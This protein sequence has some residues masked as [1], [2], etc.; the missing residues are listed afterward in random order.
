MR[1]PI[2]ITTDSDGITEVVCSDGTVWRMRA[3][4]PATTGMAW[5]NHRWEQ[6]P[7]GPIPGT[8]AHQQAENAAERMRDGIP[9]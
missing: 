1:Y 7:H 2:G 3:D 4:P 5:T 9:F 6:V 8:E